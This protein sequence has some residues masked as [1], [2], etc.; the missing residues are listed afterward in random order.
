LEKK[1]KKR[2]WAGTRL[3][4][5]GS[6]LVMNTGSSSCTT[7]RR[8][9]P[10]GTWRSGGAPTAAS[11]RRCSGPA[12]SD[13]WHNAETVGGTATTTTT[14]GGVTARRRAAVL[15]QRSSGTTGLWLGRETW[16][17]QHLPRDG[18]GV[19]TARRRHDARTGERLRTRD[20]RSELAFNPHTC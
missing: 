19:W 9:W 1:K 10:D 2:Y 11:D 3:I 14:G 17:L 18:G 4:G 13:R 8:R 6:R 7:T 15:R 16:R 12:D 5:C 20:A